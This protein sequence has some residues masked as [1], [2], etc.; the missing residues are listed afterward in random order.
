MNKC[1]I[2]QVYNKLSE[3]ITYHWQGTPSCSCIMS[4]IE[5]ETLGLDDLN[6]LLKN[7]KISKSEFTAIRNMDNVKGTKYGIKKIKAI[8]KRNKIELE[9]KLI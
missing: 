4:I 8:A 2:Q 7:G 6:R 3:K 5:G 1:I 9:I